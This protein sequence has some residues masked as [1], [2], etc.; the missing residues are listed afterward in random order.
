MHCAVHAG[1]MSDGILR[2][3]PEPGRRKSGATSK[4]IGHTVP[5]LRSLPTPVVLQAIFLSRCLPA[6]DARQS[7]PATGNRETEDSVRNSAMTQAPA[8]W[9]WEFVWHQ[10]NGRDFLREYRYRQI[11]CALGKKHLNAPPSE[12]MQ[13]FDDHER[14]CVVH[15]SSVPR[16]RR[17]NVGGE[18]EAMIVVGIPSRNEALTIGTVV[19]TAIEG[20]RR[21]DLD[22]AAVLVNCDNGSSDG[23]PE[24]FAAAAA[25]VRH[26]R[27][28]VSGH[29]TGKG[30]NVLEILRYAAAIEASKVILLDA[31]VRS[32]EPEWI[33]L[34]LCAVERPEPVVAT[35]VYRRNRFEGNTTNHIAGPVIRAAF[36]V[37]VQQPL[38]GD[39]AFNRAFVSRALTWPMPE[40]AQ[41]Y[42]I[43]V[44][45]TAQA[46]SHG[47]DIAEVPLGRKSHNPGFPKIL[48]GSQQVIDALFHAVAQHGRLSPL[49]APARSRSS[50][51]WG[52]S[53]PDVLLVNRTVSKVQRYLATQAD[54][55]PKTLPAVQ[56][57][58]EARWGL[59]VDA[60]AWA[61]LL[62][63]ALQS[64]AAGELASPRDHLVA[65][66]LCRV[67]THWEEIEG[68]RADAV[69]VLLDEQA[70]AV[71]VA[72]AQRR[73]SFT[74]FTPPAAFDA[75]YWSQDVS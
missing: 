50:T 67:M 58:P 19:A 17:T 34:L 52:A 13:K 12:V 53:R 44:C 8:P 9:A 21:L 72:V 40:S 2:R 1:P 69:D 55:I 24:V 51:D 60:P 15:V 45:L 14:P 43:D 59:R 74:A 22:G 5:C 61:E 73:I 25:E 7:I 70:A 32:V 30:N 63:D 20:L 47:V 46:A 39:F 68:L 38:A 49:G 27:L 36:G 26:A 6:G 42:G 10:T 37:E 4:A 3:L 33:S 23:T 16:G 62:A 65:L 29:R 31:D 41:F 66:Y 64:V 57:L 35:P 75:G 54:C 11:R 28:Q 18:D 56:T 71:C 48:Y